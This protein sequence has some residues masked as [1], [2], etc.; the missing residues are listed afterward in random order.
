MAWYVT[1]SEAL[2]AYGAPRQTLDTDLVVDTSEDVLSAL[3]SE[4]DSG[5]Y[6]AEPLRI[7]KRQMASLVERS[8]GG[9]V[10][11][12]VRDPDPWGREA[13]AR[14]ARWEHPTWGPIWVSSLEDLLIAKLEWSEGASEL[15]LRDCRMLLRMN[16]QRL[17]R[18]YLVRWAN[19]VGVGRLL[20][21]LEEAGRDAT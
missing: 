6:F 18:D 1:G 21:D 13:M 17:D 8:G 2:A 4:L 3:A 19:A 11:L 10:D 12:I 14:R 20:H 15:Q 5:Y 9:K 7:G 16:T